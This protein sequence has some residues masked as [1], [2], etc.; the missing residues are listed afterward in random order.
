[1][2]DLLTSR[3]AVV[4]GPCRFTLGRQ[5]DASLPLAAWLL[6]NPSMA[7]AE[8]EDA[9][10]RRMTHFSTVLG[11]GGYFAVNFRPWRTPYPAKLWKAIKA[12]S[13]TE[14]MMAANDRAISVASADATVRVVAFGV[15]P[16]R[17]DRAA[18]ER[19]LRSFLPPGTPEPFCLGVSGDGWPLHPLARG[20]S[21]I[22]NDREPTP[23]TV[24]A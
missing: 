1:M 10:S 22:P 23:W 7:D 21:A 17:R 11:C 6:C 5:W 14:D 20:K 19:A 24:P 3:T 2:T 4:D 15:E 13:I 9:T 18:L 8:I 12:G 16:G